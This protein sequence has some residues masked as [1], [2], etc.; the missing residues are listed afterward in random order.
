MENGESIGFEWMRTVVADYLSQVYI[1]VKAAGDYVKED[2]QRMWDDVN[3][4]LLQRK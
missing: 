2:D 4:W 1:A 3:E